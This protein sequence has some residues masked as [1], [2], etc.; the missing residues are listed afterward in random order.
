M[1]VQIFR[2]NDIK[3]D[4][5]EHETFAPVRV[6]V[7]DKDRNK[8]EITLFTDKDHTPDYFIVGESE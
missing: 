8:S 2:V 7:T 6:T 4:R 5:H 3:I 1:D